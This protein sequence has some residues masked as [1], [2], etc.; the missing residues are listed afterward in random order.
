MEF[1]E[2]LQKLDRL[3]IEQYGLIEGYINLKEINDT[4]FGQV[5]RSFQEASNSPIKWAL[6]LDNSKKETL[7][8]ILKGEL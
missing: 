4:K 5:I 6:K 1:Y 7:L 8:K 2:M 3:T